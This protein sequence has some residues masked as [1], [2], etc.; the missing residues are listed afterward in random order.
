M[1]VASP[2]NTGRAFRSRFCLLVGT[3]AAAVQSR[4]NIAPAQ[5]RDLLVPALHF[6]SS[7]I[8]SWKSLKI[9]LADCCDGRAIG[10]GPIRA[11]ASHIAFTENFA[12]KFESFSLNIMAIVRCGSFL[13]S[14][15]KAVA[16]SFALDATTSNPCAAL[17]I[18]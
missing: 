7:K 16:I 14:A 17:F 1:Q 13:S 2:V 18:A 9:A 3:F 6:G 11:N 8:K 12:S 5:A 4:E 15:R 10:S